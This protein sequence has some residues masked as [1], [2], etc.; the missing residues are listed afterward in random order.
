MRMTDTSRDARCCAPELLIGRL[1]QIRLLQ[2]PRLEA[3]DG[4]RSLQHPILPHKQLQDACEDRLFF[5]HGETSAS[6]RSQLCFA[7]DLLA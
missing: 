6:R 7:L 4:H 3:I 5:S 1:A 2:I